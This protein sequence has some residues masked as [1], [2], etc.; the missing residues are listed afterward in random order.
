MAHAMDNEHAT[1]TTSRSRPRR[2]MTMKV[3]AALLAIGMLAALASAARLH[4]NADR[5]NRL[6]AVSWGQSDPNGRPA[7]YGAYVWLDGREPS[8]R[9]MLT[10]YI[11]RPSLAVSYQFD[12]RD[13]GSVSSAEEAV[14]RWGDIAWSA[15]GLRVGR[16]HAAVLVPADE[17]TNHR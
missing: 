7:L 12:D 13:L 14:A 5:F 16:G 9:A 10:I 6:V 2:S 17:L 1:P 11:S 8:L 4:T 15:Q 3:L